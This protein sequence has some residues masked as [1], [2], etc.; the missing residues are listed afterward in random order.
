MAAHLCGPVPLQPAQSRFL[1][2]YAN[3]VVK[4]DGIENAEVGVHRM[5]AGV[6]EL[7]NAV[8]RYAFIGIQRPEGRNAILAHVQNA[9]AE[10]CAQPFVQTGAVVIAPEI[11]NAEIQLGKGVGAVYHDRYATRVCHVAD[12]AHGQHMASDVDH[13]AHHQQLGAGRD[14]VG[15]HLDDLAVRLR[16]KGYGDERVLHAPAPTHEF[17]LVEHRAI[18]VHRHH[19][20]VASFPIES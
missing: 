9:G 16:V 1:A 14:G 10:W 11:G 20:L 18:V 15:I 4:V 13:V 2:L 7:G 3:G 12:G 5:R 19:S 17:E 6:I 8:Q